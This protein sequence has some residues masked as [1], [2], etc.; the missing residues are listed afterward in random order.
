[1][2]AELTIRQLRKQVAELESENRKLKS[3]LAKEEAL[4][5]SQWE[6]LQESEKYIG[7]TLGRKN[8]TNDY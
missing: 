6:L 4:N 3:K 1:M 8:G 7:N 2:S 5:R